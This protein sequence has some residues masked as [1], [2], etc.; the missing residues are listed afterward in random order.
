[1]RRL[2]VRGRV[3]Q[4]VRCMNSLRGAD[5]GHGKHMVA[6]QVTAGVQIMSFTFQETI[7]KVHERIEGC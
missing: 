3:Q 4:S 7:H 6:D 5:A 2:W 1:M